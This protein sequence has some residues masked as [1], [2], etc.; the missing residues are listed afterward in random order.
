VNRER[1][2]PSEA[3]GSRV[4]GRH[5]LLLGILSAAVLLRVRLLDFP[6]ERDE[7]EYAYMGQLILRGEVPYVAAQNMKLPGVYYSY[8]AI[9]AALGES[10]SAIRLGLIAINLASILLLYLLGRRLLDAAAGLVAAAAYAVLSVGTS[11]L[12]FS[13]NAEH[14]V[15]LPM[16]GGV[17][18]LARPKS[19]RRLRAI[20]GAGLLLG[21]SVVMKQYGAAFVLFG[22]LY[23]VATR[24]AWRRAAW[25]RIGTECV[26]LGAAAL[27][28]YGL[29]CIGMYLAGGFEPFW[30]WT[31]TYAGKYT[32][33]V[34]LAAGLQELRAV[35]ARIT[36]AAPA[37]WALAAA[38]LTAPAWDSRARQ[39][40]PFLV[41]FALCSFLAVVPSLRFTAHYF[42]LLLP[43]ASLLVGTAVSA[44]AR[45]AAAYGPRLEA[46]VWVVPLAAIALA[47]VKDRAPLFSLSPAAFSRAVYATNPFPEA[48]EIA[49]YLRENTAPEER[50]AVMGSE[51]QIYFYARRHAATT[52]LYTYPLMEPQSFAR[53][54][55]EEM[56]AQLERERV[57]FLVWVNVPTSWTR[58]G[59]SDTLLF[60][61]AERT[62]REQYTPVASAEITPAYTAYRWLGDAREIVPRSPPFVVIFRRN[63][64]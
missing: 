62:L 40:A 3:A 18:L 54:M 34:P 39:Q 8:A 9:L 42:I 52:F 49:R 12:G 50:I 46:V 36:G 5:L 44:L 57:R 58:Q 2:P 48:V 47:L 16:L 32:T 20:A 63:G 4:S 17:L 13:A 60:D 37:L 6:L 53:R 27:V 45:R 19:E 64:L 28:P 35:S 10:A 31:V 14:F 22:V 41:L 51:P 25:R 21:L 59:D 26:A 15:V 7:G 33:Q 24:L 38:G 56:I 61:W 55:Q 43:A 23:L 11:A 1:D 30:F 29:T